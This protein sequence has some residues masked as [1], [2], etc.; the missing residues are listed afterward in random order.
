MFKLYDDPSIVLEGGMGSIILRKFNDVKSKINNLT[1]TDNNDVYTYYTSESNYNKTFKKATGYQKVVDDAKKLVSN[2]LFKG[3]RNLNSLVDN[4]EF[5]LF[6][7]TILSILFLG[8]NIEIKD[9]QNPVK[10]LTSLIT[11]LKQP[12]NPYKKL[13]AINLSY[14]FE[15]TIKINPNL[16]EFAN[17]LGSL[18]REVS[19][20]PDIATIPTDK[21]SVKPK[22]V[23]KPAPPV[24]SI[25][26]NPSLFDMAASKHEEAVAAE[27]DSVESSVSSEAS[28]SPESAKLTQSKEKSK[29]QP[30]KKNRN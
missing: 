18:A 2:I 9:T 14:N 22:T 5:N 1:K 20:M 3:G 21:S 12:N 11:A 26:S 24:I 28:E 4:N 23:A 25:K 13:L 17:S 6:N 10:D 15:L 19:K 8:S 7:S 29:V 27:G 16:E 30:E